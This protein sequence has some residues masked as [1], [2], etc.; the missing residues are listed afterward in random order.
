MDR[1]DIEHFHGED[2]DG[3]CHDLVRNRRRELFALFAFGS[4]A[5]HLTVRSR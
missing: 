1:N 2:I 5:V 4:I 3:D